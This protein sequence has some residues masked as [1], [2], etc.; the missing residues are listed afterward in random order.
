MCFFPDTLQK[1]HCRFV[2]DHA[3]HG[4]QKGEED[5][6]VG[7]VSDEPGDADADPAAGDG[8]GDRYHG[9][10]DGGGALEAGKGLGGNH[11]DTGAHEKTADACLDLLLFPSGQ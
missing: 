8:R 1:N 2:Q 5:L 3:P 6:P 7:K 10:G 11:D 9:K 4:P